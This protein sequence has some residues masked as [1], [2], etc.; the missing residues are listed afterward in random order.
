MSLSFDVDYP[1]DVQSLPDV[2]DFLDKLGL[3]ASFAVIGRL[4]ETYPDQHRAVLNAGHE[5]INHTYSHPEN[6]LLHPHERFDDLSAQDQKDQILRCHRICQDL[7]GV[8]P[9]G[10]RAPHFGNVESRLFYETLA[11]LGYR[12]SSSLSS[13]A[14]PGFGLPFSTGCGVWEFPVSCCPQ[15]PFA[16]LDT[17]HSFRKQKARHREKGRFSGLVGELVELASRYRGYLNLYLDP[18]DLVE[19]E[20]VRLALIVLASGRDKLRPLTYGSHLEMIESNFSQR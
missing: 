14:S 11:G 12:F 8:A 5:I 3:K 20:E 2:C 15:H 6:E 10:F 16:V 7:L 17:W 19:S 18:R 9:Q 1:E 13:A 4:V